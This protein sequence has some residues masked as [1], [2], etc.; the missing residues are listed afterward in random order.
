M[1]FVLTIHQYEGH[2]V[3][4]EERG[5]S[6]TRGRD[7]ANKLLVGNPDTEFSWKT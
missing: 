3:E 7:K 6:D 5:A 1:S 2:I 4:D